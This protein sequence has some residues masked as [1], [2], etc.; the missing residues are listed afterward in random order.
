MY[1]A[2][3]QS[4]CQTRGARDGDLDGILA[5]Y[6][7]L[8]PQDPEPLPNAR[9]VFDRMLARDDVRILVC[10]VDGRLVS[11]CMLALIPNLASGTRPIGLLEHVVT[12][13]AHRGHGYARRVLEHALSVA[14]QANCC[15]VMLLSGAQRDDAHRLYESVGFTGDVERGFVVK[16]RGA[17]R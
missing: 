6:R 17:V 11:T 10:E 9:K 3:A 15:K 12:L 5:L 7:E 8:R 2:A 13:A 4:A 16:P 14:W 1:T